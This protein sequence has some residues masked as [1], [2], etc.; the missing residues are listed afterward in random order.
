VN[1]SQRTAIIILSV[2][3]FTVIIL[4]Q[5][6]D[7][8][9]DQEEISP[10]EENI[11]NIAVTYEKLAENVELWPHPVSEEKIVLLI[12]IT[13]AE[14]N[15]YCN[16]NQIDTKF[17]FIPTPVIHKG[18]TQAGENPP[19]LDEMVQLNEAGINLIVGHDYSMA[20]W[21]SLDYAT[22]NNMLLLS[23]MGVGLGQSIP[24]DNL[25]K[26]TP[27]MYEDPDVY[28]RVYAQMI[29]EL[30]Y[31]AFI[32]INTGKRCIFRNLLD[33]TAQA[34]SYSYMDTQV[35]F[36]VNAEDFTPY[37]DRAAEN[38]ETAIELYGV[39]HVCV[40]TEQLLVDELIPFLDLMDNRSVFETVTWYDFS[41][42]PEE[43]VIEEGLAPRLAK[44]GFVQIKL[45]P[46]LS[47]KAE[48][49]LSFY[50]DKVGAYPTP[51]K[52]YGE[53]ARYDAMW[54]M[55]QAVIEANSSSTDDVKKV[56]PQI[57]REYL[58]VIGNCT[59]NN[60]GDRVSAD[61]AV[62]RWS[63]IEENAQFVNI[64]HYDS[65][66]SKLRMQAKPVL[67]WSH[68][69][70]GLLED[71]GLHVQRTTDGGYIIAGLT[72]SFGEGE[73][74][75]YL[76]KTDSNGN[77]V[78]DKTIG[79]PG[80]DIAYSIQRCE[81]NSYIITGSTDSSE[82][83]ENA[84]LLKIDSK[85]DTLWMKTYGDNNTNSRF[86]QVTSD[87]GFIVVGSQ[88]VSGLLD[89]DFLLIRTDSNGT[90][91]WNRTFDG[92][93]RDLGRCVQQTMDGGFIVTGIIDSLGQ[94]KGLFLFKV[95]RDGSMVWNQSLGDYGDAGY[96]VQEALDGGFIVTGYTR[97]LDGTD[98]CLVK[99][100]SD[101]IVQW[102]R[103]FGGSGYDKGSC[104]QE[105]N[106]G[107]FVVV[108]TS[109]SFG[110]G[111]ND[112]FLFEVDAGGVLLW[113]VTFGGFGNDGGSCVQQTIDGGF[114]VSGYTQSFGKGD[115]DVFLIKYSPIQLSR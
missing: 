106:D 113:N 21:Y 15:Q 43:I 83:G 103:S 70:G 67:E 90:L 102:S 65:E 72:K 51:S 98:V 81:N 25:Y 12:N 112:V 54:I 48:E 32:S 47:G 46:S 52:M 11:V 73:H 94:E 105:M 77:K 104:V 107:D 59:L 40:L 111:D 57:C 26:L 5:D 100:D 60:Y 87:N 53:A 64:G 88:Q 14:I 96:F 89:L 7:S 31:Q 13:G 4:T 36:D 80:V 10:S 27:N 18:G 91:L 101:G 109:S 2:F 29:K 68:T 9:S 16:E 28:D 78:W 35:E 108:G 22:E 3:L 49:F 76:L 86:V 74:D 20:N 33:E 71:V 115:S 92:K 44:Y 110:E 58:G 34:I 56:L 66:T 93:G 75:I 84:F 82:L 99:T 42:I 37:L 61:Y 45:S 114:I 38:L 41:G 8:P 63:I 50:E 39:E 97:S 17:K 62:Y 69:F 24:D 85:G 6:N 19:G 30:G 79:G 23:P 1:N 95:D 55:A